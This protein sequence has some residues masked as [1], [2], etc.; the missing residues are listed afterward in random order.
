MQRP[1]L[2]VPLSQNQKKTQFYSRLELK[3]SSL[4]EIL[5]MV[6]CQDMAAQR[7]AGSLSFGGSIKRS[8]SLWNVH[9]PGSPKEVE[10]KQ[11]LKYLHFSP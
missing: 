11:F 6:S 5:H 3:A 10:L 1:C 7:G 4:E 8:K 2:H 9:L